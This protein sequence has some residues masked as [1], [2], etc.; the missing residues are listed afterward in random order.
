MNTHAHKVQ[1]TA[2]SAAERITTLLIELC[3]SG[4]VACADAVVAGGS[5]A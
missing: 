2:L 1:S 4:A 3:C 5:D